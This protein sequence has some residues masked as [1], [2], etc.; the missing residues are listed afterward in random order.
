M[1]QQKPNI[2]KAALNSLAVI[3]ECRSQLARA[4]ALPFVLLVAL[5]MVARQDLSAHISWLLI[6]PQVGLISVFFIVMHRIALLG[7]D[8]VP[9]W[10]LIRWTSRETYFAVHLVLLWYIAA[11]P[12]LLADVLPFPAGFVILGFAVIYLAARLMLVLPALAIDVGMSLLGSWRMTKN[13]QLFMVL[14]V[15]LMGVFMVVFRGITYMLIPSLAAS[16]MLTS[17]LVGALAVVPVTLLSMAYAEI[18]RYE[19]ES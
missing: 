7:P 11:L 19:Y 12:I 10:G 15:L 6:V 2:K 16:F 17:L 13:H 1:E 5:S 14:V 8:S 3:Y 4:L 18:Y 9:R